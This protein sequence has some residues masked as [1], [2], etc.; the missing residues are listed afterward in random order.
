MRTPVLLVWLM[1]PVL[2]GAYHYGPGQ[3]QMILDDVAADL[4]EADRLAGAEQWSAA[5]DRYSRAL[6]RLPEGREGEARRIRLGRA[7][8]QMFARQLPE[9]NVELK[10]LVEELEADPKADP[11]HP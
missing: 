10:A 7:K 6:A 9:A 4:A 11:R 3:R 5:V 8:A 1:I 2:V